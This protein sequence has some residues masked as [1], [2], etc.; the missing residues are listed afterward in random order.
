MA[1][2]EGWSPATDPK[3]RTYYINTLTKKTQWDPPEEEQRGVAASG[4]CSDTS[5]QLPAG[6]QQGVASNGRTY[7]CYGKVTQWERPTGGAV[8]SSGAPSTSAG[9]DRRKS[10]KVEVDLSVW[11]EAMQEEMRPELSDAVLDALAEANHPLAAPFDPTAIAGFDPR[12]SFKA[13]ENAYA[14]AFDPAFDEAWKAVI[15]TGASDWNSIRRPSERRWPRILAL[16]SN[17]SAG[18]A[19][20]PALAHQRPNARTTLSTNVRSQPDSAVCV[21]AWQCSVSSYQSCWHRGHRPPNRSLRPPS[22][23]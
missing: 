8:S 12:G 23:Q 16:A 7:Y 2:P 10:E 11:L 3:G 22:Q 21:L 4:G 20:C 18:L 9:G 1:L 17:P 13:A 5:E 19:S 14:A 6:W 15:A